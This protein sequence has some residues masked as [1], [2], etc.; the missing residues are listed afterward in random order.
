VYKM[1]L[2]SKRFESLGLVDWIVRL[3]GTPKLIYTQAPK[4]SKFLYAIGEVHIRDSGD[5]WVVL[6]D[7]YHCSSQKTRHD[8]D[9]TRGIVAGIPTL[10][11]MP[12]AH[13]EEIECQ[14]SQEAY[15]ERIWPDKPVYGGRGCLYRIQ[16][17]SKRKPSLW[18]RTFQMYSV[19]RKAIND[20][21]ATNQ[22]IQEKYDEVRNPADLA[23]GI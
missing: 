4:Y 1:A 11:D 23:I 17:E 14:V 10:F 2:A 19:Y 3:L 12:L 15:G 21:Q 18:K 13:V 7:R 6:E 8:C 9:Y 20:L 16:W 22:A 5:S